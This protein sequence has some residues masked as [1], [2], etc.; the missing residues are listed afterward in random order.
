MDSWDGDG[1]LHPKFSMRGIYTLSSDSDSY[2][3]LSAAIIAQQD[4]D[5]GAYRDMGLSFKIV[6]APL[7]RT[8]RRGH[9]SSES[10]MGDSRPVV[11]QRSTIVCNYNEGPHNTV[12]MCG[13]G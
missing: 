13:S 4:S 2:Q 7:S 12:L 6:I 8:P 10:T 11:P 5:Y 1:V 9:K 3:F